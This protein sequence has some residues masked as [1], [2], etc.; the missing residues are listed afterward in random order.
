M[1]AKCAVLRRARAGGPAFGC[2]ERRESHRRLDG[3]QVELADTLTSAILSSDAR[4]D[5]PTDDARR[6]RRRRRFALPAR[7]LHTSLRQRLRPETAQDGGEG[8]G[9][10]SEESPSKRFSRQFPGRAV[11]FL[12]RSFSARTACWVGNGVGRRS[13]PR[14]SSRTDVLPLGG[15]Q[16]RSVERD[17]RPGGVLCGGSQRLPGAYP[18]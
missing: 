16:G 8:F 7:Q 1:S 3:V 2:L 6:G 11:G 9:P 13:A 5:R 17:K 14:R 10:S 12:E 4:L 15:A 18:T